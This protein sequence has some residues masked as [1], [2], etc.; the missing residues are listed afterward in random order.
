MFGCL[1]YDMTISLIS[2]QHQLTWVTFMHKCTPHDKLIRSKSLSLSLFLFPAQPF[3]MSQLH[4]SYCVGFLIQD[5]SHLSNQFTSSYIN[6]DLGSEATG[7]VK[8]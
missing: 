8:E 4:Y 5:S 1:G 7:I 3:P 6:V 2:L